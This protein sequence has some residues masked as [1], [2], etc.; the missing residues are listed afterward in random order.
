MCH[1][2]SKISDFKIFAWGHKLETVR[3]SLLID[4]ELIRPGQVIT[5][6]YRMTFKKN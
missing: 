3:C 2:E 4:G 6:E 1:V 5:K